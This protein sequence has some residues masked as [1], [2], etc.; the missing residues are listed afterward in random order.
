M[1]FDRP[2]NTPVPI[3]QDMGEIE[4]Q[5]ENPDSVSV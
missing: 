2:L 3:N 1:A 5:I 4:I